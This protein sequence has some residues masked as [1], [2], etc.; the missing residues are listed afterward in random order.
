MTE[1]LNA[2]AR[3]H[4]IP[5]SE[6]SSFRLGYLIGAQDQLVKDYTTSRIF[7]NAQ[8]NALSEITR[9]NFLSSGHSTKATELQIKEKLEDEPK[10][11]NLLV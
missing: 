1:Q 2:I 8:Q 10:T 11:W 3:E 9:Q 7:D 6:L 5:E 4:D